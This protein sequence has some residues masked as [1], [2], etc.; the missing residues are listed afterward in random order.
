MV[1]K[2]A[3]ESYGRTDEKGDKKNE[4]EII[5]RIMSTKRYI[6]SD[7]YSSLQCEDLSDIEKT[8]AKNIKCW[9]ERLANPCSDLVTSLQAGHE[10]EGQGL[11]YL[12]RENFRTNDG[13]KCVREVFY[14]GGKRH[15]FYREMFEDGGMR[16]VGRYSE[17][18]KV[19]THW[20]WCIGDGY[21]IG[22]VD[23]DDK[24]HG[25]HTVYLYPDIT[26]CILASFIHGNM[27]E[28]KLGR[29]CAIYEEFRILIPEVDIVEPS[30]SYSYS[31]STSIIITSCPL[32]RDPYEQRYVFVKESQTPGAGEGLW[33]KA[34]I[35]K[36]QVFAFY[37]GQKVRQLHADM[38]TLVMSDYAIKLSDT[39][40]L[41][42]K[43]EDS[44]LT[45][46]CATLVHKTCHS[47]TPNSKF[48]QSWHPR[49]GLIMALTAK[50]DIEAGQEVFVNYN[51]KLPFSPV[52]YQQQFFTHLRQNLQWTE[53]KIQEWT[54]SKARMAGV[55]INIPPIQTTDN[56]D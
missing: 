2:S 50:Q 39:M 13:R 15:G 3:I 30:V 41:D 23:D 4:D 40:D 47:F 43:Y 6:E 11:Q 14:R 17:G 12:A 22:E 38:K 53:T 33:A 51:Y 7:P 37:N 31:P 45:N 21:L 18:Q 54:S 8:C 5:E 46:Y 26:T 20:C 10:D 35:L 49:F 28:G 55:P 25:D 52:W 56:K 36:D 32:L 27:K 16:M 29:L 24:V 42:I 34:K 48:T 1:L 44:L 19:G 9:I